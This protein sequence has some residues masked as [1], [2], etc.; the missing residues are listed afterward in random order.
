MHRTRKSQRSPEKGVAK[1]FIT[2]A[3]HRY[4]TVPLRLPALFLH[5]A[6]DGDIFQDYAMIAPFSGQWKRK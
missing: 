1:A 2:I 5:R 4:A 3:H 6:G